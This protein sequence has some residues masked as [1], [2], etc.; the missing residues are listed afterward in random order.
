LARRCDVHAYAHITGGG[1]AANLARV[2]PPGTTAVLDR[3]TWQPPPVFTLLAGRGNVPLDEMERVFNMGDGMTPVGAP[4][5]ADQAVTLLT[6]QGIPAWQAGE[7][8]QA[9][10]PDTP[11]AARLSGSYAT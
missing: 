1:L 4:E 8:T 11:G 7:V 5:A 3:G 2:L 9:A 10:S 6:E